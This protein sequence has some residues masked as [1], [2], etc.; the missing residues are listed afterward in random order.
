LQKKLQKKLSFWAYRRKT[1]QLHFSFNL[2]MAPFLKWV[3]GKTQIIDKV[4]NRFP[5]RMNNYHEPFLGGGSVLL[6]VLEDRKAGKVRVDGTMY[7][8]DSNPE[9]I[10]AFV[11]VQTNVEEVIL[12]LDLISDCFKELP[13]AMPKPKKSNYAGKKARKEAL[14]VAQKTKSSTK[15]TSQESLFYFVRSRLRRGGNTARRA[16]QF[17]FLNKTCH[18]GVCRYGPNGFNVAFGFYVNPNIFDADHLREVS[19]LLAAVV[20]TCQPFTA[21]LARVAQGDFVYGDPPYVKDE[22]GTFDNYTTAG[23]DIDEHRA[24]FARCDE[25]R[26][27][28]ISLLLSNAD[29]KFVRDSFPSPAFT[30]LKIE[31]RHKVNKKEGSKKANEVLISCC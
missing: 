1:T 23:F 18:R 30:T 25:I 19:T 17:I 8:S 27:A 21:S 6:A 31:V 13:P 11:Q 22:E 2:T 12:E 14:A 15:L 4:R 3:G 29:V 9:L 26:K 10:N 7:A 16:A 5:P 20:F 24:L 28:G